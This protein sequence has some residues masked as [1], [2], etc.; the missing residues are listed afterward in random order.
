MI[1]AESLTMRMNKDPKP[2]GSFSWL[3][4]IMAVLGLLFAVLGLRSFIIPL[5]NSYDSVR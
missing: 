1:E 3:H 4:F 2:S 5:I